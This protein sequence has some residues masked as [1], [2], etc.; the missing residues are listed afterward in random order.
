MASLLTKMENCRGSS[1]TYTV[2]ERLGEEYTVKP[3]YPCLFECLVV[4]LE[5]ALV[6]ILIVKVWLRFST[7]ARE[8][9]QLIF[10]TFR[11]EKIL[12]SKRIAN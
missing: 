8:M 7:V 4:C 12:G 11:S 10:D 2:W 9:I 3:R 5:L 6:H 1:C